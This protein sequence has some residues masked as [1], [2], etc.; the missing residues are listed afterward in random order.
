MYRSPHQYHQVSYGKAL[1][2]QFSRASRDLTDYYGKYP[3]R[4]DLMRSD[5][6]KL[7]A[8]NTSHLVARGVGGAITGF[9]GNLI[10]ADDLGTFSRRQSITNI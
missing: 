7:E 9:G 4:K 1:T 6:Y 3:V 10:I 2:E 5:E 8:P